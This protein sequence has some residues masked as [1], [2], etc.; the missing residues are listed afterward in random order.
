MKAFKILIG[1]LLTLLIA[2]I[3]YIHFHT[4]E[5]KMVKI[6]FGDVEA[7]GAMEEIQLLIPNQNKPMNK[8]EILYANL[9]R[10]FCSSHYPL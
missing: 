3:S 9:F 5:K 7:M 1:F 4:I 10:L 2:L 6:A 8:L